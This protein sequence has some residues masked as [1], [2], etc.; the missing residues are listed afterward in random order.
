MP[1]FPEPEAIIQWIE[2]EGAEGIR[3]DVQQFLTLMAEH[4]TEEDE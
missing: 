3:G 1:P 2:R 4:L